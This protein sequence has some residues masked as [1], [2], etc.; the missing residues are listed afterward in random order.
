MKN[1]KLNIT[2][3][4]TL[5]SKTQAT[6]E[7]IKTGEV[8]N[9]DSLIGLRRMLGQIDAVITDAPYKFPLSKKKTGA[10][11]DA[12]HLEEIEFMSNGFDFAI[13]DECIRL[14]PKIKMAIYCSKYQIPEYIE[15]FADKDVEFQLLTW[16]KS[17]CIPSLCHNNYLNS[18]EYIFLVYDK[19]LADE[20]H[21]KT[22][23][24]ITPR[25]NVKK[26]DELYHPSTKIVE[27]L[28]DLIEA[29]TN[30][31]DVICDPFAGSGTLFEA[32]IKTNRRFV[33]FEIEKKYFNI[34]K[35][36]IELAL[37]ECPDY[38]F[39]SICL[40]KCSDILFTDDKKMLDSLN[41]EDVQM[42]YFD[43]CGKGLDIPY[44]FIEDV[45]S[46]QKKPNLYIMVDMIQFADVIMHFHKKDYKYEILTNHFEDGTKFLLFF[47]KGGVKLYGD[48]VTKK[49]YYEDTRDMT[50]PYQDTISVDLMRKI[51][52]NSS[53]P[54]DNIFVYGG[55]GNSIE[56]V[57]KEGRHYIAYEPDEG[58]F[59]C[60]KDVI[61]RIKNTEPE[62]NP[63]GDA[64]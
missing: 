52:I 1:K 2:E 26:S 7:L 54:G 56:A 40:E 17:N 9:M 46:K 28:A 64:A 18:T 60:C 32:A 35:K 37:M 20:I 53:L 57:I 27:Q 13:L 11:K 51:V 24:Y 22:D 5:R 55:Y 23:Y 16:N 12:K 43:L 3:E 50:A 21:L 61:E 19:S 38:N 47:R 14:M 25:V 49:K 6:D 4:H 41:K 63:L 33:G 62:P 39:E 30:E 45:V 15:Y 10:A 34:C 31:G 36:R 44:D 59:S 48:Y 58:K 42:A 8:Y 29:L